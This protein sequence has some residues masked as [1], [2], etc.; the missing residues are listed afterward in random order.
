MALLG[1][2]GAGDPHPGAAIQRIAWKPILARQ[3][4]ELAGS[5]DLIVLLSSLPQSTNRKIAELYAKIHILI[6]A[7]QPT[8]NHPPELINNTLLC[9]GGARGKYLALL[10]INWQTAARW[11][12]GR[13][14]QATQLQQQRRQDKNG[15]EWCTYTNTFIPLDQ[16]IKEDPQVRAIV[17]EAQ[18]RLR[19]VTN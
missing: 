10:D 13:N 11:Q 19:R 3:M 5:A 7:G 12:P 8:G 17:Q 18:R 16:S 14:R 15:K 9:Q 1:L 6:Q 2:S 4:E